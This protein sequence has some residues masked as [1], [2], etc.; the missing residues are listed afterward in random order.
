MLGTKS[1]A[2]TAKRLYKRSN[3]AV[4]LRS[5]LEIP[6]QR[7]RFKLSIWKRIL[8]ENCDEVWLYCALS[9]MIL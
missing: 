2:D 5:V 1:R 4:A 6:G 8:T 7:K 3:L 9:P